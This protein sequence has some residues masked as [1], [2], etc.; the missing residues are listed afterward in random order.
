MKKKVRIKP[1]RRYY[2]DGKEVYRA[3]R[4]KYV[5]WLIASCDTGHAASQLARALN[6]EERM[7]A[8]L[9]DIRKTRDEQARRARELEVAMA[10]LL[11]ALDLEEIHAYTG[12]KLYFAL[13]TARNLVGEIQKEAGHA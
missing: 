8:V 6:R 3:G 9:P 5:V 1:G 13:R 11:A 2:A 7:R 12:G 4:Q 10:E